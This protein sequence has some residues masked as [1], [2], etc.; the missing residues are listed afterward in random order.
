MLAAALIV[1]AS[2]AAPSLVEEG[3]TVDFHKPH[4]HDENNTTAACCAHVSRYYDSTCWKRY[5]PI[6]FWDCSPPTPQRSDFA[7]ST[8][9]C[10]C[11]AHST[12]IIKFNDMICLNTTL[13]LAPDRSLANSSIEIDLGID[14]KSCELPL[15]T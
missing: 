2:T 7:S 5:Q 12:H 10:V 11:A 14:G 9:V 6:S 15:F 1:V 4:C 8:C 3:A 13:Q